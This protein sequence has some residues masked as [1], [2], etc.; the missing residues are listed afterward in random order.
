MA[1]LKLWKTMSDTTIH[2]KDISSLL[3]KL[4][5]RGVKKAQKENHRLGIANVYFKNGKI[6][7]QLPNGDITTKKP[8]KQPKL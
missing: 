8:K 5:N 7:Y 6:Y 2:S 3:T 1:I 4:G